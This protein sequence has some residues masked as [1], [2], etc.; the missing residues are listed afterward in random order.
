MMLQNY[1]V[2][3]RGGNWEP[4]AVTNSLGGIGDV[5]ALEFQINSTMVQKP[6]PC[7]EVLRGTGNWEHNPD[8]S[9]WVTIGG[10]NCCCN[11]S[12]LRWHGKWEK[13][14]EVEAAVIAMK[15]S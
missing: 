11:G 5:R 6:R 12:C 1:R 3:R 14:T 7:R 13:I 2:L 10:G 15:A 9:Q 8:G 4:N